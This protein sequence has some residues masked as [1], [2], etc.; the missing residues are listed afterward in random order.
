MKLLLLIII[1]PAAL[2]NR[3]FLHVYMH[4]SMCTHVSLY[5]I[6]QLLQISFYNYIFAGVWKTDLFFLSSLI[7][8]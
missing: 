4:V 5:E 6:R 2:P 7:A 3:Q 1:S 8:R